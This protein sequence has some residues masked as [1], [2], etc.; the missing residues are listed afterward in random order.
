M[1]Q[2]ITNRLREETHFWR[3]INNAT[4]ANARTYHGGNDAFAALFETCGRDW[5]KFWAVIKTIDGDS[6]QRAQERDVGPIIE[7]LAEKGCRS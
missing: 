2:R 5:T 6:F 4:L 3:P 1:K 7:R